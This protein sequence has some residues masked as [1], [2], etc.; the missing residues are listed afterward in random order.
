MDQD[1]ASNIR[2]NHRKS[3]DNR[4]HSKWPGS[5]PI[6]VDYCTQ[7]YLVKKGLNYLYNFRRVKMRVISIVQLIH[8]SKFGS[9]N[10]SYKNGFYIT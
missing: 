7:L 8:S 4:N 5:M 3:T 9:D 2:T 10:Y 6:V 1:A